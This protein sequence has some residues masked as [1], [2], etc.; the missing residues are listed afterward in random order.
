MG[1]KWKITTD[2]S[3]HSASLDNMSLNSPYTQSNYSLHGPALNTRIS[4]MS[5]DSSQKC[6][7]KTLS[8]TSQ[9]TD[10]NRQSW[11]DPLE[12]FRTNKTDKH[13]LK[14]TLVWQSSETV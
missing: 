8:N 13:H 5:T 14:Q 9:I 10:Q 12:K 7:R 1:P 2:A 6:L 4:N 3:K 11:I